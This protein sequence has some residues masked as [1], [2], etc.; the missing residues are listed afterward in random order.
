MTK[1]D[2]EVVRVTS[3]ALS[4]GARHPPPF[5]TPTPSRTREELARPRCSSYGEPFPETT[6]RLPPGSAAAT[7][8]PQFERSR[9][10]SVPQMQPPVA[11]LLVGKR[12]AEQNGV[13]VC[14]L[15]GRQRGVPSCAA[16]DDVTAGGSVAARAGRQ[17]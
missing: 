12:R 3:R 2:L 9:V 10:V 14:S 16:L 1:P 5:D 6:S 8:S 7:R 4:H 13:L 15:N 11:G 17:V